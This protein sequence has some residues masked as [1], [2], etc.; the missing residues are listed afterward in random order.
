[1]NATR[2]SSLVTVS[3]PRRMLTASDRLA[4]RKHMTRSEFLRT[5]LRRYLEETDA[6]ES[7]RIYEEEKRKRKLK[8]VKGSIAQLMR[9]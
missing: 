6:L 1:M 5:A 7:I 3:L 8:T 4:K 9:I 2:V